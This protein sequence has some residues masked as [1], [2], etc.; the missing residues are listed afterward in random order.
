MLESQIKGVFYERHGRMQ[1]RCILG[2]FCVS[3]KCLRCGHP[4]ASGSFSQDIGDFCEEP[5]RGDGN[6]SD[7]Q[8]HD[9]FSAGWTH[10]VGTGFY[11]LFYNAATGV[12]VTGYFDGIGRFMTASTYNDF[13][14]GWTHIAASAGG[15][16]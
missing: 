10:M 5:V 7:L 13:S 1:F 2:D 16:N 4:S 9:D 14:L 12:G 11:V 3:L 15:I 8:H 6:Y